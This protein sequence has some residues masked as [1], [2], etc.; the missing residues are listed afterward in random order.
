MND[1]EDLQDVMRS[2]GIVSI[3]IMVSRVLGLVR[4][5]VVAYFFGSTAVTDAFY[6]AF[7]IPNLMRDL[8][9]EGVLSKAFI[10]TFKITEA[11]DGEESA[12]HLSNRIF[13]SVAVVLVIL[14]MIGILIAPIIVD[15]MFMGRGFDVH[16]NPSDHFGFTN[17]RD[18]TVYLTRIMFPFLL[19]VSFAAIAMGILNGRGKFGVPAMASSFF[20]ISTIIIGVLGYHL[21]PKAGFHPV[22]GLAVGT[23]VGGGTQFFIQLP[24]MWCVGF[25]YRLLISFKDK[26][27]KQVFFLV[28]PAILGVAAVQINVLVNGMFASAGENWLSWIAWAFRLMHLPIGIFGVAISTVAL[29]NLAGFVSRGEIEEF[30]ESFSFALRLV[31]LL[32]IP[33]SVGLMVL[34][35]P[36]CQ[37]IYGIGKNFE[38]TDPI[39]VTLF[40][41]SFGLCGYSAVKI[42]TDGFYAF[43]DTKTPVKVSLLA[44]G[45]NIV[46]NYFFIFKLGLEYRSLAL[47]TSCT[48]TLNFLLL[49]ILLRRKIGSLALEGIWHFLIKLGFASTIMGISCWITSSIIKNQMSADSLI[50]RLLEVF[51]PISTGLLV[52]VVMYKLLKIRELDQLLNGIL[53][54]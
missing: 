22:T 44:V 41:Y 26:R 1:S 29:P 23:L 20:N 10:T 4:E 32:T 40:F 47:S 49:L 25:R 5:Q 11:E 24:S 14:T 46:L 13:N 2:V 27:V 54:C 3:A 12:W 43:N 52:L 30:R 34:S 38:N 15:L 17:K 9:G 48:I 51:L 18:L 37:L 53:R 39:A 42:V 8:F 35:K 45:L 33:A 19:L 28:V 16:L 21:G 6:A 50:G 31:F 7:R 36:I